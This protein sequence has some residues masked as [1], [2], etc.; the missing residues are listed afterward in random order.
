MAFSGIEVHALGIC[1]D[2]WVLE[3]LLEQQQVIK[4]S[5]TRWSAYS[6]QRLSGW[7][8]SGRSLMWSRK[9]RG[10]GTVPW[11]TPDK[12]SASSL[13]S[14]STRTV[15]KAEIQWWMLP[16]MPNCSI[17]PEDFKIMKKVPSYLWQQQLIHAIPQEKYSL[18][19]TFLATSSKIPSRKSG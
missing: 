18:A 12:T 5:T 14:Q 8:M 4:L 19:V 11:G 10:Q 15:R 17:F 16:V 2:L 9:G 3:I 13:L 7:I 1:S 6:L